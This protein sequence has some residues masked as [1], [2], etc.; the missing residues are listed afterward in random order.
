MDKSTKDS[1]YNLAENGNVSVIRYLGWYLYAEESDP[2]EACRVYGFAQKNP[3]FEFMI[4]KIKFIEG[5][6][7]AL[8]EIKSLAIK[9]YAPALYTYGRQRMKK[10]QFK[11]YGYLCVLYAAKKGNLW[12]C[13]DKYW[14]R[15][16]VY[17][18]FLSSMLSV[19]GLIYVAK[20]AVNRYREIWSESMVS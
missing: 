10:K 12:A 6:R 13:R 11:K 1:F 3:E 4:C 17:P 14:K 19:I 16:D 18:G 8:S 2:A 9:G 15:K 7:A 5:N 20:I